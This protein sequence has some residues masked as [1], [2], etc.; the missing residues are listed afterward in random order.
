[1]FKQSFFMIEGG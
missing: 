1:M